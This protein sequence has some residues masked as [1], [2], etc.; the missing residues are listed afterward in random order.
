MDKIIEYF[1]ETLNRDNGGSVFEKIAS[2]L[3][4]SEI[5]S[6]I[7]PAT[8]PFGGGDHGIDLETHN[9]FLVESSK[10][11]RLYTS[12]PASHVKEKIIFAFSIDKNWKSKLNKDT[13]KIIEKYKLKPDSVFFITNQFIK[14]KLR[15]SF[16]E[17]LRK[18]YPNIEFEILDGRWI[19]NLLT[20]KHYSLACRFLNLPEII[21]P[22][23]EELYQ[24]VYSFREGGMTD[25]ESITVKD[26]LSKVAY[27]STYEGIIDQRVIDLIIIAD[28]QCK[29]SKFIE[30]GI[31]NYEEALTEID[32]VEDCYLVSRLYYSL[33]VAYQKIRSY[34]KIGEKIESY[35]KY[36]FDNDI[37]EH[38]KHIFTWLFYLMP[39]QSEINM[40]DLIAFAE[41]AFKEVSTKK[42][43]QK[44]KHIKAALREAIVYGTH[45]LIFTGRNQGNIIELWRKHIESVKSIPL[46]PI[47]TMSSIVSALSI[48][49]EGT[50]EYEELY[51]LIEEI[52]L[53]RNQR[54]DAAQFR[55]DR[56]VNLYNVGKYEDVIHHLLI[57][58]IE[59]YSE[60]TIRGSMLS[61]FML[62]DCYKKLGLRYAAIEELYTVAHFTNSDNKILMNNVDLFIRSLTD[63]YFRYLELGMWGSSTIIGKLALL[64]INKYQPDFEFDAGETFL[65]TFEHNFL[66]SCVSEYITQKNLWN[67]SYKLLQPLQ[68]PTLSATYE[69]FFIESDEEFEKNWD[70]TKEDYES[71]KE[72][73][74]SLLAGAHKILDSNKD[75]IFDSIDESQRQQS[76]S[77]IYKNIEIFVNFTNT[78][79]A[80]MISEY[81]LSFLQTI[82]LELFRIAS[83]VWIEKKIVIN[84]VDENVNTFELREKENNE[85]LEYDLGI[86]CDS[87]CKVFKYPFDHVNQLERTLF[88]SILLHCTIDKKEF[89]E[90][91][92][93]Q[94][95]KSGFLGVLSSK[96]PY[97][98]PFQIYF[99]EDDYK[100]LLS[101]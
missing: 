67:K 61:S 82:L 54:L 2:S 80:K 5:C 23:V 58:K 86:R 77:F 14:N 32:N 45:L 10:Q 36:I 34:N 49:Y 31:K 75:K 41:R 90:E 53:K 94:L 51:T 33:F 48:T 55:K 73:R 88:S 91:V 20:T 27:R 25:K 29:Y 3:V 12:Q 84:I 1:I 43:E 15:E 24:R 22:R 52:M 95:G 21:D 4:E 78:Y 97:S 30:D 11:F 59:W 85:Y 63:I 44:P 50:D 37:T 96:L 56:A 101:T 60:E 19:S 81:I 76:R 64:A 9:S 16:K 74:G 26:L 38:F 62:H 42:A 13:A 87:L 93:D 72:F 7:I 8:G 69:M 98:V 99:S 6:N 89:V 18:K 28:I 79:Q 39:H 17:E 40:V 100:A 70:G 66:L 47:Q 83:F 92:L 46:Y 35:S 65:E 71:A 68:L 57:V